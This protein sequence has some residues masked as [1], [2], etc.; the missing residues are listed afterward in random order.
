MKLFDSESL[1]FFEIKSRIR[2]SKGC[3]AE[4]FATWSSKKRSTSYD[5]TH[6][7]VC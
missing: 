7:T 5:L 3:F 4:Q 2:S 6:S 1:N